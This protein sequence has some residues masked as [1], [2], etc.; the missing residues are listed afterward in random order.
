MNNITMNDSDTEIMKESIKIENINNNSHRNSPNNENLDIF[1]TKERKESRSPIRSLLENEKSQQKS[2][3]KSESKFKQN[4]FSLFVNAFKTSSPER[5]SLETEHDHHKHYPCKQNIIATVDKINSNDLDEY[6]AYYTKLVKSGVNIL[7]MS[8]SVFDEDS[9]LK[10]KKSYTMLKEILKKNQLHIP[11]LIGLEYRIIRFTND[12][13]IGLKA[14]EKLYIKFSNV[15]KV[16]EGSVLQEKIANEE[17]VYF[18][19]NVDY[20]FT[21]KISLGDKIIVDFGRG[22]FTITKIYYKNK[23][24]IELSSIDEELE[25]NENNEED[26]ININKNSK[27]NVK[28][29][30]F[31]KMFNVEYNYNNESFYKSF[32]ENYNTI[33]NNT[34]ELESELLNFLDTF[35]ENKEM[36]NTNE[37]IQDY[38]IDFIECVVDYDCFLNPRRPAQ[39]FKKSKNFKYLQ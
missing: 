31:Q 34:E 9:Y 32:L 1:W 19:N 20:A 26:E 10:L 15:N 24:T 17:K 30:V 36:S 16:E 18:I 33:L 6:E 8:L 23:K 37:I 4:E 29:K 28:D 21:I 39:I 11:I 25:D 35:Y 3:N 7:K 22:R 38:D 12:K 5:G 14:G 2:N 13:V 27:K